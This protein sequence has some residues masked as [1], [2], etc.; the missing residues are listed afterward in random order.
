MMWGIGGLGY[1]WMVLTWVAVLA[2]AIWA[3]Q[4]RHAHRRPKDRAIEIL[5]ERY[6]R[7]QIDRAEFE[8]RKAEL[9]R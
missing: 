4:E 1:I 2:F 8:T 6:A 3:F 9:T 5:T 7:G